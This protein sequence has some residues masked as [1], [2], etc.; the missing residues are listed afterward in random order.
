MI[1][2]S[3]ILCRLPLGNGL[4]MKPSGL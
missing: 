1:R 4:L 3:I 2:E